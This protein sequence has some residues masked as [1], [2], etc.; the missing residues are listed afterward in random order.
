[1]A[2]YKCDFL[3]LCAMQFID[4]HTHLYLEEFDT[5][6]ADSIE[7]AK[8]FGVEIFLLPNIDS[9]SIDPLLNLA[10]EFP[11]NCLPMIGLHP[12][13]VKENFE[14]ELRILENHLGKH[15]FYAVGEIGIDLYWDKTFLDQ[16]RIAFR[17]QLKLAKE[18]D[19]PVAIHMRNS[20]E[21]TFSIVREEANGN[22][23][24]VFHCFPGNLLQAKQV[25]D[26][27]FFLGIGGVVTFKNSGLQQ[28]VKEIPLEFIVLETDAPFLAPEPYRGKRNESSYI[29]LIAEK[30]AS[31]KDLTLA[32]VAGV[33]T[34]NAKRLFNLS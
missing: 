11:D 10:D 16:Q 30:I 15:K 12:T 13:S 2:V 32:E 3:Y 33:T 25:T 28:V 4:T 24:G 20:F 18:A 17:H 34:A 6:R 9:L 27:G 14:D 22:L 26:M 8:S 1:M 23:R 7:R 31:L 5:D 29:P 19:L 21:H